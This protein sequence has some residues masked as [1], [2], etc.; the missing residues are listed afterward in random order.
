MKKR[1]TMRLISVCMAAAFVFSSFSVLATEK[2]SINEGSQTDDYVVS[3]AEPGGQDHA[4]ETQGPETQIPSP[5]DDTAYEARLMSPVDE[6]L[7]EED[8]ILPASDINE[9]ELLAASKADVKTGLL[10]TV[11]HKNYI[12]GYDDGC[13]YPERNLKRSEASKMI[14]S[15][16]EEGYVGPPRQ[17]EDVKET[18]W[19]AEYVN[20]LAYLKIV[21]GDRG[22]FRP[23]APITRAE[24]VTIMS[25]FFTLKTGTNKFKDVGNHWAK[26]NIINAAECGWITGYEDGSFKPDARIS[27][28]EA[29][30]IINRVLERDGDHEF[31][32]EK[33][34]M[35][36]PDVVPSAWYY[37][38]VMEA[39][40]VHNFTKTTNAETGAAD[41]KWT[42]H[43]EPASVLE[44]GFHV[45][46]GYLY[47]IGENSLLT[48]GAAV[49][50][51]NFREENGR[52]SCGDLA[53]D[54][55]LRRMVLENTQPTDSRETMRRKLYNYTTTFPYQMRSYIAK[56]ATGWENVRTWDMINT[57]KGNCYSYAGLFYNL[58]R[59]VGYECVAISGNFYGGP[60]AWTEVT[61]DGIVYVCDPQQDGRLNNF[62][63]G[64][65]ASYMKTYGQLADVYSK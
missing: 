38:A 33:S 10:D 23:E 12:K 34:Y 41:E 2:V 37:N 56:G 15:L 44:K 11:N 9:S 20:A 7:G 35:L 18:A 63:G 51:L 36:F 61:V 27:R 59:Y 62:K 17:F 49:G 58:C 60:H 25:R 3:Y 32:K 55:E 50:T 39:V 24:F 1:T 52:Y 30:V 21:E 64:T 13:F 29:V 8:V 4:S 43:V 47:H 42:S 28:S 19:Y 5:Q 14:Y 54:N 53:L 65:Y 46:N 26:E 45:I 40:T 57:K 22:L 16:L 6:Q 31:I 48:K